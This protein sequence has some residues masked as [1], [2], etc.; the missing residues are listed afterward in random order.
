M[1]LKIPVNYSYSQTTEDP[2]YNPLNDDVEFNK[3]PKKNELKKIART[4]TQQRSLGILNMRKER[5]NPNKKPKF[6]DVEN[7]SITAIY[8]DD[9]YRDIYTKTNFRQY[10]RGNIDYNFNFKP[11]SLKPFNKMVSDTAKSYKY[12]RWVKEISI[13]YLPESLSVQN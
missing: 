11:W 5:T 3:D 13:L 2:K 10:L 7:I 1:G 6:Y 12:L 4:F 9:F 8:N